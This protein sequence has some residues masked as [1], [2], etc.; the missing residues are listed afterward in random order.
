L[1]AAESV[2]LAALH[3]ERL[4][5]H[6]G[7]LRLTLGRSTEGHAAEVRAL[8]SEERR[9]GLATLERYRRFACEVKESSTAFVSL[10]ERLTADGHRVAGY[11][12]PAKGNTL[13]NVCGI[14]RRLISYTVDK[15]PLKVGLYTPGSHIPV[16]EVS[17][18]YASE[19]RPDYVV[20]LAWNISDE[21]MKQ[22]RAFHDAGGR[23]IIPIPRAQ[24]I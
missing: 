3:I 10:L 12:A 13:M 9:A 15:S 24:V 21:I 17:A 7:S 16:R 23:F 5:V 8:E 6:G 14:D 18:L 4:P 2:D 1:R 22:E 19:T 20:I 11:A